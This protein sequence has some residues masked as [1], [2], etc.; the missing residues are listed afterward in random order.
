MNISKN[1]EKIS[2]EEIEK[3]I[4][5][6]LEYDLGIEELTESSANWLIVEMPKDVWEEI[7][8]LSLKISFKVMHK[9][10]EKETGH[11]GFNLTQIKR[12]GLE[13]NYVEFE[14]EVLDPHIPTYDEDIYQWN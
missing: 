6:K 11:N 5:K 2:D 14:T 3:Y 10:I 12:N 13:R 4:E 7:S 8:K 9:L 1:T